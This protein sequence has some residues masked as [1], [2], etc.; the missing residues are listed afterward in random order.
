MAPDTSFVTDVDLTKMSDARRISSMALDDTDALM[1]ASKRHD[2]QLLSDI[3]ARLV[4]YRHL[5]LSLSL[6]V[7]LS[8]SV[9]VSRPRHD[10]LPTRR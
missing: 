2:Q 8:F 6:S 4:L 7:S 5:S 3:N 1:T 9:S 10:L